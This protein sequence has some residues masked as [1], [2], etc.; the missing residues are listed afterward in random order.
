MPPRLRRKCAARICRSACACSASSPCATGW[1][2]QPDPGRAA[3]TSEVMHQA[4]DEP[5]RFSSGPDRVFVDVEGVAGVYLVADL[6][7]TRVD[8]GTQRQR[9]VVRDL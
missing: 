5:G 1:R 2:G 8:E 6:H 7:V 4:E 9:I 3:L